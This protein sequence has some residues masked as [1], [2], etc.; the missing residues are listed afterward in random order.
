MISLRDI[1]REMQSIV[2]SFISLTENRGQNSLKINSYY[3]PIL[4]F[5]LTNRKLLIV[6]II[7]LISYYTYIYLDK[8]FNFLYL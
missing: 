7:F 8:F 2:R 5:I 1:T 6:D 3:L 4:S